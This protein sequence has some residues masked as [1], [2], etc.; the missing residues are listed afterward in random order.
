MTQSGVSIG[1]AAKAGSLVALCLFL[2]L[3]LIMLQSAD[4]TTEAVNVFER[5]LL[6]V[7]FVFIPTSEIGAMIS[8][9]SGAVAAAIS[10]DNFSPSVIGVVFAFGFVYTSTNII[11]NWFT[12]P[13]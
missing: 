2:I 9:F 12:V 3:Y 10:L 7:I 11:I 4:G 6:T 1:D 5:T 8:V 13:V